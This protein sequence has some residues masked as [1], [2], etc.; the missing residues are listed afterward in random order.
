[1]FK[2]VTHLKESRNAVNV[3]PQKSRS[4]S[5]ARVTGRELNPT[6]VVHLLMFGAIAKYLLAS[7]VVRE[8]R[9]ISSKTRSKQLRSTSNT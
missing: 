9:R 4:Q 5:A 8:E 6:W 1:M 2:P 3:A 7:T